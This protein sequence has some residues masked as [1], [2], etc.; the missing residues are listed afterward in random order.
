MQEKWVPSQGQDP[1][2]KEMASQ[3]SILAW[4]ISW[5]EEP[6][7]LPSLES[8][9]VRHDWATEEEQHSH[10]FFLFCWNIIDV[11]YYVSFENTTEGFDIVKHYEM[12]TISLKKKT[13]CYDT[14]I[15]TS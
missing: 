3:S 15:D 12:I 7:G 10:F 4:R 8:Q 13:S 1:L 9:R 14:E 11:Q 2:E 5:T 6:A